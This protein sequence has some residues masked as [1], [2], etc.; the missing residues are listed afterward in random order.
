M[1]I[2]NKREK[3]LQEIKENKYDFNSFSII[4]NHL[5]PLSEVTETQNK[6]R[7]TS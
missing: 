1:D 3:I 2:F 5:N 6:L 4:I 7:D